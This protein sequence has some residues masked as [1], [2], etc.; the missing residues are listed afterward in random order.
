MHWEKIQPVEPSPR[1]TL[2]QGPIT[3]S[4]QPSRDGSETYQH[5]MMSFGWNA[6][7]D[8][9][10]CQRQFPVLALAEARRYL[11]QFEAALQEDHIDG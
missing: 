8:T 10:K 1:H 6:S 5:F 3:M 9:G 4:V 11:D 7:N 2:V